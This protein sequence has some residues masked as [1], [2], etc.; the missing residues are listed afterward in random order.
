MQYSSWFHVCDVSVR[1]ECEHP[2]QVIVTEFVR[3]VFLC[4]PQESII[5]SAVASEKHDCVDLAFAQVHLHC[6]TQ[7]DGMPANFADI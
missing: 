6:G 1:H 3:F 2:M 7:S 5:G 4:V